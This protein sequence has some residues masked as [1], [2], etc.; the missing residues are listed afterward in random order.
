VSAP[1][2]SPE[3]RRSPRPATIAI[4]AVVVLLPLAVLLLLWGRGT[5]QVAVGPAPQPTEKPEEAPDTGPRIRETV[6]SSVP[7]FGNLKEPR[8]AAWDDRGRL[9]IADFGNSR[10]RI[11]DAEGGYLGGW[12]GK[13]N[14]P[15]NFRD[16]SAVTIGGD[17][18]YV[19]DT[20]NGR[21]EKFGIDGASKATATGLFGPRGIA[22][23][24]NGSVWVSDTGNHRVVRYDSVLSGGET[25]GT[26]GAG[27]GQFSSPV[28][29][30]V[31]PSGTVYVADTG[32]QRIVL[33]DSS[34]RF[35]SSWKVP[36]WERPVEPHF[37][38]DDDGSVWATDPGSAEALLHLGAKG[39]LIDRRTS[40]REGRRFS[41]P[42]GLA[43]DRKSRVLY[44]V[45]TGSSSV[46]KLPV[47]LGPSG[48]P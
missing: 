21:V 25:F 41:L 44:V 20:W 28:G 43:L 18:V 5:R 7:P 46:S 4:A 2:Q 39:R 17:D 10:L 29:I 15:Y 1:P 26:Q 36:G 31:G 47:P 3:P 11:Y 27:P 48:K 13:G 33:L 22:V 34:G 9:W 19:A 23:G 12:G 35:Q 8:D 14:G 42:T 40:D 45:N 24:S 37:E 16:L 30:A 38:V 32:N 6:D